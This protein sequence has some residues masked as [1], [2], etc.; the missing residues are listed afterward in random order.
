MGV[1]DNCH[2]MSIEKFRPFFSQRIPKTVTSQHLTPTSTNYWTTPTPEPQ[3]LPT[4]INIPRQKAK[5][6]RKKGYGKILGAEQQTRKP[7]RPLRL[8]GGPPLRH[9]ERQYLGAL[10]QE[11]PRYTQNIPSSGDNQALPSVG[12]LS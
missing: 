11:P 8:T 3:A 7:M 6:K 1:S 12:A 9:A 10:P 5:G 2:S 4:K